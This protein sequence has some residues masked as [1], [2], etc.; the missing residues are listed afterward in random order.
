MDY[1][2]GQGISVVDGNTEKRNGSIM[3]KRILAILLGCLLAVSTR[4][5]EVQAAETDSSETEAAEVLDQIKDQLSDAFEDLDQETAG[6]IFSFVKEKIA[7]GALT[8][9]EELQQAIEEGE[10]KFGVEIDREAAQQV[11]DTMEKL[12]DM[13]FSS[14][15]IINKAEELYQQYGADFVEHADEVVKDAVKDA[16]KKAANSFWDGLKSAVVDFFQKMF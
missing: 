4:Y 3:K 16:V 11:V 12:E 1:G 8:S 13:G 7:D 10:E 2:K 9:E 14:E 6:E 5:V 15:T